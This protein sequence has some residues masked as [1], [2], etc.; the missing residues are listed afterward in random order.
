MLILISFC[1]IKGRND[2]SVTIGHTVESKQLLCSLLSLIPSVT[3]PVPQKGTSLDMTLWF[4][5]SQDVTS[6]IILVMSNLN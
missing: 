3:C 6:V 1:L 5:L 4:A 2:I